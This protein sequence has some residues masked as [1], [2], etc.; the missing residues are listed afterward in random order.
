ML[1]LGQTLG[2]FWNPETVLQ[3]IAASLRP[4]DYFLLGLSLYHPTTE[5]AILANYQAMASQTA[6]V[7]PLMLAGIGLDDGEVWFSF[8]QTTTAVDAVFVF[9]RAVA[10]TVP[11]GPALHFSAGDRIAVFHSQRFPAAS[12]APLLTAASL[13]LTTEWLNPDHTWGLYLCRRS[14]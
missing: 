12:V 11:D 14:T 2:N 10:V 1:L 3:Q 5:Q 9:T 7:Q 8:D 13:N 6:A 4:D